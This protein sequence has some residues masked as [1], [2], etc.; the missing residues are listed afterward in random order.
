[1][2]F[3]EKI[4]ELR[5]QKGLTQEELAESLFVSRTAVSKWESGAAVPE[6]DKIIAMSEIFGVSTDYLLKD[7]LGN[8]LPA[9]KEEISESKFRKVTMEEANEFIKVKDHCF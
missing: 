7:E 1:M 6:I 4:Q 2:E 3:N 9:P 8:E 5:K